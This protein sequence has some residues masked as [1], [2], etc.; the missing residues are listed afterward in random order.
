MYMHDLR[1]VHGNLKGIGA[2]LNNRVYAPNSCP[3][4]ANVLINNDRRACIADFI[5]AVVT[6]IGFS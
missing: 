6:G 4:K 1:T 5:L 2:S 3:L